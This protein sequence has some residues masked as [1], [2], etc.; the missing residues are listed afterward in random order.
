[1]ATGSTDT[2]LFR[3]QIEE[4]WGRTPIEAY[5]A[6]EATGILA[7]QGWNAKG[8]TFLPDVS[9]LEFIPMEEHLRS[10]EDPTY[11]PDALLLDEVEAGERYELV[12]TNFM[13]GVFV[14][15]RVGDLI[16]I[17]SLEDEEIGIALPQ[18]TFYSRADDIIDL[19]AFTRLS[20]RDVWRAMQ[21][22]GVAYVDWTARKEY[23][24]RRP[25]LHLYIELKGEADQEE[26]KQAVHC[27][28]RGDTPTLWRAGRHVGDR[29]FGSDPSS[30]GLLCAIL[31]G[32]TERRGRPGPSEASSHESVR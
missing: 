11:Q 1:L 15:Y 16:E 13:G 8:L 4:Y 25:V 3:D 17:I 9:F 2:A 27:R 14:R 30:P 28:L 5:A 19:A 10:K 29:R 32:E 31:S 6:T 23:L 20:E 12:L 7:I 21:E 18:M 24:A 22:A 26:I